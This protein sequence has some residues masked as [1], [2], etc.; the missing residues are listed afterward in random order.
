MDPSQEESIGTFMAIAGCD[1]EFAASFLEANGWH[2]ESAVNQ[3]TDPGGG[4]MPPMAGGA[5][6]LGGNPAG[7]FDPMGFIPKYCDT[8]EKMKLMKLKGIKHGRIAMIAVAG[9]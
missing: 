1:R 8:P 2:L 4:G 5:G 7:G 3:F 9:L 6:S